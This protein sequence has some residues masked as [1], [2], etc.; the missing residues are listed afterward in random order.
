MRFRR[1]AG[2][3]DI[4][5]DDSHAIFVCAGGVRPSKAET[6]IK[7]ELSI[8]NDIGP[9]G[10]KGWDRNTGVYV[11]FN[12][13][14]SR[15]ARPL[16]LSSYGP[17]IVSTHTHTHTH[18]QPRDSSRW[19]NI[20]KRGSIVRCVCVC[21][22]MRSE[23]RCLSLSWS[24]GRNNPP[25]HSKRWDKN[26]GEVVKARRGLGGYHIPCTCTYIASTVRI[27]DANAKTPF[28]GCICARW[29]YR[30]VLCVS[31]FLASQAAPVRS[32]KVEM[33]V[34]LNR[35]PCCARALLARAPGR[36]TWPIVKKN[37]CGTGINPFARR[38]TS[39]KVL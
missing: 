26:A 5:A 9:R 27:W 7:L 15:N 39:F 23:T 20:P 2:V 21:L 12:C 28:P 24:I 8:F 19:P 29:S 11:P 6:V 37:V 10:G 36:E 35:P 32:K 38:E 18:T 33:A 14:K 34:I 13:R 30:A 22:C 1:C 31:S 4:R 25:F 3:I 17:V 16:V